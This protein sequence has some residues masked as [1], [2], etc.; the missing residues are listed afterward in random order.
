MAATA[1][2][3]E[4]TGGGDEETPEQLRARSSRGWPSGLAA[5]TAATIASGR[6]T[7][8]VRLDDACIYFGYRGVG[9][10]DIVPIGVSGAR[11]TGDVANAKILTYLGTQ[12]SMHDDVQVRQLIDGATA[13][14]Y[15]TIST[16][17]DFISGLGRRL[18]DRRRIDDEPDHADGH[19]RRDPLGARAHPGDDGAAPR[20]LPAHGHRARDRLHRHRHAAPLRPRSDLPRPARRPYDPE[21]ARRDLPGSSIGSAPSDPDGAHRWPD[22]A[23]AWGV[24]PAPEQ[25]SHAVLDVEGIDGADVTLP[26]A[27]VTP[28]QFARV[29]PGVVSIVHAVGSTPPPSSSRSA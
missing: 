13:E 15:V 8:G 17:T 10:I 7:P 6:A 27:N 20:D 2:V 12:A 28:A 18:R 9:T 3:L 11:Q 5:G 21:R 26:A 14:V 16:G 22:G 4:M 19:E 23:D 1:T 29:R 24:D 25:I